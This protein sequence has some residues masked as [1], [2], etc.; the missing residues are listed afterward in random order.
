[1]HDRLRQIND[2]YETLEA[3]L[4][5]PEVLADPDQL[6]TLSKRY[7]ELGPVVELF[8]RREARAADADAARSMLP[9]AV[10]D[11]RDLLS[12]EIASVN[13][14]LAVMDDELRELMLP[15]DPHDGK[16]VIMEIRGAE[17]GE[18]ANL[19]ARDLFEMYQ[20]YALNQGWKL[21]VLSSSVSDMGGFNDITFEVRGDTAWRNLKFEGGPHRVQRVPATESQ[22][23]IHTSSSTVTVL[24]EVDEVDVQIDDRDL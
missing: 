5:D 11:E 1:M 8:R 20:T 18:E 21:S 9:D 3:Q 7:T 23:R 22:G 15:A 10:G 24:P 16:N 13:E 4:S 17:G 2:E 6:R 19:F 12:D 14:E